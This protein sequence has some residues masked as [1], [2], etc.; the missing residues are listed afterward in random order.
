MR[1]IVLGGCKL[2]IQEFS[3]DNILQGFA[4]N[5]SRA[6][7]SHARVL[8]QDIQAMIEQRST[9]HWTEGLR[10]RYQCR[11][12]KIEHSIVETMD[13][14]SRRLRHDGECFRF[15]L[16]GHHSLTSMEL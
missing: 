4:N 8:C 3:W 6:T 13:V 1:A 9:L 2:L 10:Q 5:V 16:D 11:Y 15:E 7:I 14:P 12:V